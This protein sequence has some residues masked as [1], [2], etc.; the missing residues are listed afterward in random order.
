VGTSPVHL[1]LQP[2]NTVVRVGFD[3]KPYIRT[4]EAA[5][6]RLKE[7]DLDL[8]EKESELKERVRRAENEHTKTIERLGDQFNQ[9]LAN[10]QRLDSTISDGEGVAVRIGGQLE[11]LEKQRQRAAD[12]V[13][14]IQCYAEFSK[15]D[16][17]RLE[18]LR[19]TGRTDDSVKCA[20]VARQLSLITKR[21]EAAGTGN[22]TQATNTRILVERFS[23]SLEQDLLNQFDR[24]YKK[25]NSDWAVM[26]ACAQVLTDFN[27]GDS[28]IQIFVNQHS[29]F[30]ELD[31]LATG[32]IAQEGEV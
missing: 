6:R 31:N 10:F 30:I 29:F 3:P 20:V 26:K 14:L 21:M 17:S 25:Q 19:K 2:P 23:E 7:L 9:A 8:S 16:T 1:N 18:R 28:V 27:G 4:F 5:L 22:S 13:F 15:G 24:A 12:A 11:Q 32:D